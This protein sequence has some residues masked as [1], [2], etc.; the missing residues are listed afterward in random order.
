MLYR[1]GFACLFGVWSFPLSSELLIFASCSVMENSLRPHVLV[2]HQAPL[3]MGFPREEYWCGLPFP[4]PGDFPNP[5]I[6]WHLLHWHVDSLPLSHK[7][8]S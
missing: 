5:G 4:S 1:V 2:A 7:C 8:N 6:E 3:T